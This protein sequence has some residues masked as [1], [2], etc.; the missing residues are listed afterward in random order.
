MKKDEIY[1]LEHGKEK[2]LYRKLKKKKKKKNLYSVGPISV[3]ITSRRKEMTHTVLSEKT[4]NK[5][6]F[7]CKSINSFI[8]VDLPI[9]FTQM[10]VHYQILLQFQPWSYSLK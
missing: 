6:Q 7:S 3:H 9:T 5:I 10:T 1:L 2:G 8:H 4:F